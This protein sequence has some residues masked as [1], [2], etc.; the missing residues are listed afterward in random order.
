MYAYFLATAILFYV[1]TPGVFISLPPGGSQV[2]VTA[3]HA[4]V[5]AAAH[6]A[7]HRYIFKS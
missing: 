1:L 5:F 7:M 6:I 2:V 3:T 4:I